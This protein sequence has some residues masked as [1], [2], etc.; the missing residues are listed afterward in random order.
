MVFN[1]YDSPDEQKQTV[2]DYAKNTPSSRL[3]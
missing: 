1:G 3:S 2:E